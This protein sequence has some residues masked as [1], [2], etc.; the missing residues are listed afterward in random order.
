MTRAF[1]LSAIFRKPV[2]LQTIPGS[3]SRARTVEDH[4]MFR[5]ARCSAAVVPPSSSRSRVI[6]SRAA[7]DFVTTPAGDIDW[8]V[9]AAMPP[10]GARRLP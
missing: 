1:V 8:R 6:F 9:Y 7:C 5:A 4:V 10:D 3:T 2:K